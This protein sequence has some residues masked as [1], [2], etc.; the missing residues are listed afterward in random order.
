M[1]FTVRQEVRRCLG[2]LRGTQQKGRIKGQCT[3]AYVDMFRGVHVDKL[4]DRLYC[5]HS[6]WQ[7]IPSLERKFVWTQR[8]MGFE[9]H[10][11]GKWCCPGMVDWHLERNGKPAVRA[12]SLFCS[13]EWWFQAPGQQ[14]PHYSAKPLLHEYGTVLALAKPEWQYLL[15]YELIFCNPQSWSIK[16]DTWCFSKEHILSTLYTTQ[17]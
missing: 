4:E 16:R 3:A 2:D 17:I 12:T 1:G 8:R 10:L 9:T 13:A 15:Y 6:Q 14:P 11:Q 7:T 5:V